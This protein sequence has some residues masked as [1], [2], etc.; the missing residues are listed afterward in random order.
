M[1]A[2]WQRTDAMAVLRRHYDAV[3]VYGDQ[4]VFDP[5]AEY[6]IPAD[7]ASM[8]RF[9]GYLDRLAADRTAEHAA[10]RRRELD[11]PDG[12][13]SVCLLGGGEDGYRLADA[14]ARARLPE[15]STGVVV[16]GPFMPEAEHA[17]LDALA[18]D[19]DDLR[20]LALRARRRHARSGWP[21]RSWPWAATTRA[22]RSWPAAG[23]R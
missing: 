19:R 20:V 11:L 15:G 21:T 8:V 23:G 7:V 10:R 3:W 5:V 12:H 6:G 4:R 14:F 18:R 9:S 1:R 13:L 17:A 2:E 16:T 22:A